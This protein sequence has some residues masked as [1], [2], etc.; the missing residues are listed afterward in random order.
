MKPRL[1]FIVASALVAGLLQIV[2]FV[3]LAV[4]W[5][6][7]DAGDSLRRTLEPAP[8]PGG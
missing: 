8:K 5:W 1:E 2:A 7:L 4:V 3:A 6:G